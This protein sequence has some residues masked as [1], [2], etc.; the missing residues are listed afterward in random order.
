M[1]VARS[2][3]TSSLPFLLHHFLLLLMQQ[4]ALVYLSPVVKS[5][6]QPATSDP[7]PKPLLSV[8]LEY[9][10][11]GMELLYLAAQ[12]QLSQLQL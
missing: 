12:P 4:L 8:V 10:I 9:K 7:L 11:R 5:Y 3:G 6:L 2:L 1:E